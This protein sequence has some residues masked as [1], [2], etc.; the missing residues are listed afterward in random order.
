MS[1]EV[2]SLEMEL[3]SRGARIDAEPGVTDLGLVGWRVR[4]DWV[5]E[6]WEVLITEERNPCPYEAPRGR[7]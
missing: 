6:G 2:F 5:R 4:S 3:L 7:P 1:G